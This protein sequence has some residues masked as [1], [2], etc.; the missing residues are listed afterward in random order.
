MKETKFEDLRRLTQ[1]VLEQAEAER[2]AILARAR[3]EAA[4]LLKQ[5]EAETAAREEELVRAGLSEVERQ[6]KQLLSQA[7]LRLKGELLEKKAAILSETLDAVR[8]RLL[9]LRQS[10]GL[11][12][13]WRLIGGALQGE[14]ANGERIRLYLNRE[15]LT[16]HREEL[17]HLLTNEFEFAPTE[18]EF[19]EAE[20][21]GGAIVE[22]PGRRLQ[23]D[24]T[25][26][27]FLLELQPQI[28]KLVQERV[29]R[30]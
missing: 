3:A 8:E 4:D 2:E 29:F 10:E 21:L 25:I 19:A 22:F 27:R 16:R 15:D 5:T 24:A 26:E 18:M 28:E 17:A 11:P 1:R 7:H 30:E 13:L 6:R 9:A 23:V 14:G 20:L 12:L